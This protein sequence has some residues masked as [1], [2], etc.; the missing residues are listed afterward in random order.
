MATLNMIE[1]RQIRVIVC[2]SAH[3]SSSTAIYSLVVFANEA[4]LC[5]EYF[6]IVI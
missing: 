5:V 3:R 1:Q 4:V 2:L 6:M